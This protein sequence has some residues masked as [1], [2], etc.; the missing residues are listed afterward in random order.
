M[1]SCGLPQCNGRNVG[2]GSCALLQ[3]KH[4]EENMSTF[5]LITLK[6]NKGFTEIFSTPDSFFG[7][8]VLFNSH[9]H[10][11]LH[12]FFFKFQTYGKSTQK[13]FLDSSTT[14]NICYNVLLKS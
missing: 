3:V 7:G 14:G 11:T 5:Y 8:I 9:A 12:F 4:D 13:Y 2:H 10:F 1:R 6:L